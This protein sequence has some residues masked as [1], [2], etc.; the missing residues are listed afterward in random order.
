MSKRGISKYFSGRKSV[1]DL[2]KKRLF[3]ERRVADYGGTMEL[4]RTWLREEMG[5]MESQLASRDK[6]K[7]IQ[8][9]VTIVRHKA[10]RMA[11]YGSLPLFIPYH[12]CLYLLCRILRPALVVETGVERGS[13]TL[14]ILEAMKKNR[15]GRLHSIEIEPSV[16]ITKSRRVPL[17]QV[18]VKDGI[19][20]NDGKAPTFNGRWQLHIAD[21]RKLLEEKREEW[22]DKLDIFIH[23]SAHD[24]EN[25]RAEL[26]L[27][28]SLVKKE[29]VIVVDRP[30][31]NGWRAVE[32]VFPQDSYGRYAVPER[33]S[34]SPLEFALVKKKWSKS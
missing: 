5:E 14:M 34:N 17:A 28:K 3:P 10:D 30:D 4:T 32:E 26:L 27:G 19:T 24:Y 23:G 21:S 1:G 11:T 6:P 2:P 22:G 7:S 20:L 33:S 8:D 16:A 18:L 25:Q 12:D 13:S 15:R 31:D 29:G 9:I